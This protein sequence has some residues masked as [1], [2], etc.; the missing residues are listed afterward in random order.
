MFVQVELMTRNGLVSLDRG[1]EARA[2]QL[3][4]K[5]GR[6]VWCRF[7]TLEKYRVCR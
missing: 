6:T 4:G 3:E 2:W 7:L 1:Q 5:V